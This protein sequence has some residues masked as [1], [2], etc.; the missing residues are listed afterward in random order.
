MNEL[1]GGDWIDGASVVKHTVGNVY[2]SVQSKLLP[3]VPVRQAG[4]AL[5]GCI[6]S[7]L[8]PLPEWTVHSYTAA[9]MAIDRRRSSCSVWKKKLKERRK[10]RRLHRP[11]RM[12]TRA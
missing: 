3:P 6:H 2:S 5:G 12:M 4:P 11:R 9:L 10:R 7:H 1:E 8:E